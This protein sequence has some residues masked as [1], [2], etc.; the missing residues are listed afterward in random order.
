M[1]IIFI[2]K[3]FLHS[4]LFLVKY[5]KKA[6]FA[7]GKNKMKKKV[8]L[9]GI[10]LISAG[11]MIMIY[12]ILVG[13]TLISYNIRQVKAHASNNRERNI[14]FIYHQAIIEKA[15]NPIIIG[16]LSPEP[17]SDG[18]NGLS[19]SPGEDITTKIGQVSGTGN[20][21]FKLSKDASLP[22]FMDVNDE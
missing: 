5:F 20:S 13:A 6:K 7:V 16:D 9:S 4:L 12:F 8:Q 19:I 15:Q 18:N 21:F 2:K 1:A 10:L 17:F 22:L 11:F 3:N 14:V